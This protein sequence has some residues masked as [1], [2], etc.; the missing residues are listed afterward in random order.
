[1]EALL[2][3]KPSILVVGDVMIDHYVWGECGRIS[4][5]APVPVVNI[6]RESKVLGGG[7]NV[8]S[9]L[10]AFGARVDL[11]SCIGVCEVAEEL[12]TLLKNSQV[13]TSYLFSQADR[14]TTKKTRVIA[15]QQQIVRYDRETTD[16]IGAVTQ[17]AILDCFNAIV[18]QYDIVLM[19][20]Y[21]KG[22]L[23][24]A[25]TQSLI[26]SANSAGKKVLVDPKGDDFSKYDGAFL[27]TPNLK[28]AS[29]ATGVRVS[30]DDT[31]M[32]AMSCLKVSCNLAVSIITLSEQGIAVLD[33]GLRKHPAVAREV[34]DITG[35]GDTVLAALGFSLALD[36]HID[37]A[38]KFA[39]LAAG[40][41][42]AKMGSSTATL[43][44]IISSQDQGEASPFD[45]LIK[46]S[47]EMANLSAELKGMGKKI[48]FTN[49]C[50]DI[51]HAGHVAYLQE[52]R[53][54]G[55]VLIVGI[56]SDR[57]V[58]KLKG[59]ERPVN[60][61]LDRARI[62]AAL[63]SVDYVVIFDEETPYEIIKE[64]APHVLVKGGDYVGESI[65]GEDLVEEVKITGFIDERSTTKI[66]QK[67][68]RERG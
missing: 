12:K 52:A 27:L 67:V 60:E 63:Q 5:E 33:G 14:L 36:Y 45:D 41:V 19:S 23:T 66:I 16:D 34:F 11:I 15:G 21:G 26:Q 55:D 13:A 65:V 43:D 2:K 35:A 57:S 49:G 18:D 9:N 22:L 48:V 64:L 53:E 38:I 4:P 1:M 37:E 32:E 68:R 39:N 50:F 40:I 61:Q 56:N 20:D 44:E 6:S 3:K 59:P 8:V 28:E 62:I 25:L 54:A 47:N 42:V 29:Q 7:G 10:R 51:L 46:S 58:N 31:L 30:D 17:A 24:Y